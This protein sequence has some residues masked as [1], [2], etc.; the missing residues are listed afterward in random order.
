M[1]LALW[2]MLLVTLVPEPAV[3]ASPTTE[4]S[5]HLS[6]WVAEGDH[7]P[8]KALAAF[9]NG[10]F[11]PPTGEVPNL[12]FSTST[13]WFAVPVLNE[14]THESFILNIGYPHLDLIEVWVIRDGVIQQTLRGGDRDA[15][16]ERAV[17]HRTPNV[18]VFVPPGQKA[19]LLLRVTT[20]SSISM[21]LTLYSQNAYAGHVGNETFGNGAYYGI[22]LAMLLVNLMFW[23]KL[24]HR[25]YGIYVTY[26]AFLLIF[27]FGFSGVSR[28]YLFTSHPWFSER[29]FLA[30]GL[31]A[32]ACIAEF[33]KSFL[34]LGV[35]SKLI[36]KLLSWMTKISL[37][38]SVAAWMVP[39]KWVII[40]LVLCGSFSPAL[41]LAAAY[42]RLRQ[43]FRPA[44]FF[45]LAWV[46]FFAGFIL[47]ALRTAGLLPATFVTDFGGQIGS[48]LEVILLTL[49][50][51]DRMNLVQKERDAAN[52]A[53]LQSYKLLGNEVAKRDELE[54]SNQL[55]ATEMDRATEQLVQADKLATLGQLVA[56]VAHDIANPTSYIG[57]SREIVEDEI[58][59]LGNILDLL[60]GDDLSPEARDVKT[61]IEAHI[62]QAR[63]GLGDIKQGTLR[64]AQIHQ[65]I[66]NQ[67]RVDQGA[68]E[69]VELA[70]VVQ[71]AITMVNTKLKMT[72]VDVRVHDVSAITCKRSQIGQVLMNLLSNAADAVSEERN[73]KIQLGEKPGPGHIQVTLMNAAHQ[74]KNG[75][76][77][78][79]EDTGG[80]IAEH[81]RE[82][83][84]ESFFTTKPVGVGTGLGLAICERIISAHGGSLIVDDSVE[85]GGAN[86]MVWLPLT[87]IEA[88]VDAGSPIVQT[89]EHRPA[90]GIQGTII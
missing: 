71:E 2:G 29:L 75:A 37:F 19:N 83:V 77:I 50:L 53:A 32:A 16:H 7:T 63:Q 69:G 81:N 89:H 39:Y 82:K 11:S 45:L 36:H 17:M 90:A 85:F 72:K 35:E 57:T 52:A 9:Q 31:A 70:P 62:G 3:I 8:E 13:A 26:L 20:E 27:Q 87:H 76:V 6:V 28:Q 1:N 44:R 40:A 47:V 12:G 61:R 80:G 60:F 56:G 25:D 41:G 88:V 4:L 24:G 14:T 78:R 74:G 23:L 64:I 65:A 46:A 67:S 18:R 68:Q 54:K 51:A 48:A 42:S 59:K 49:A 21:P 66:R 15:F 33:S 43:G 84:R 34:Q 30:C 73:R 10:A 5:G 79:V 55:L 86:L 22:L 38:F 58:C